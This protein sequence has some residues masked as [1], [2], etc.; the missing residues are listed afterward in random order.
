MKNISPQ[1]E[2]LI[3]NMIERGLK[4][5][6]L[7]TDRSAGDFPFI[8][9]GEHKQ[10]EPI[11]KICPADGTN[12]PSKEWSPGENY[13]PLH[14]LEICNPCVIVLPINIKIKRV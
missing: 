9:T 6:F 13:Y 12:C 4:Y 8:A 10:N 14:P 1:A 7:Y 2:K 11:C 3:R 5:I